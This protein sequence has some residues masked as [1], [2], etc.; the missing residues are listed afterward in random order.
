MNAV[1]G[2]RL[3]PVS[4]RRVHRDGFNARFLLVLTLLLIVSCSDGK[5]ER[6]ELYV[7]YWA[8]CEDT[9]HRWVEFWGKR[10]EDSSY[11]IILPEGIPGVH[12]P[13]NGLIR[14][15]FP[16][17]KEEEHREL[18]ESFQF[19]CAPTAMVEVPFEGIDEDYI[20]EY[21][22]KVPGS[23]VQNYDGLLLIRLS[24]DKTQIYFN[25]R[26]KRG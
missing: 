3:G 24:G 6:G 15:E 11:E 26:A 25:N 7:P 2:N 9:L 4:S 21:L 19:Q 8:S 23:V 17:H 13:V 12:P 22:G 16:A 5:S 20:R 14:F 18:A 10:Y 1:P